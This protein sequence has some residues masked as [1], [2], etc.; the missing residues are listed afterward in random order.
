MIGDIY[1]VCNRGVEKREVFYTDLDYYRFVEGLYKFNNI[2]GALRTKRSI[3]RTAPPQDKLV[4]VLKW[5]LLPNHYHLLLYEKVDGG[6]G[7][8]MRRVG[9][10]YTKYFNIK[11]KRSGYLFQ[12][13]AKIIPILD[14]SQFLYI[15]FYID[16]NPVG[17]STWHVDT[18]EKL[19]AYR[20]SSLRNYYGD[21]EFSS[22]V[23][24]ELFYEL[25]DTDAKEYQKELK[26]LLEEKNEQKRTEIFEAFADDLP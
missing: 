4:E 10:G 6:A 8:F 5:T 12:N 16:L 2:A 25:F 24:K 1:H 22:V 11:N 15:P 7:E 23:N 19:K 3:L 9:N 20:W 26:G 21:I 13:K 17:V 18:V 14:E